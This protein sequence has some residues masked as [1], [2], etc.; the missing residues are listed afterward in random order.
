MPQR[1]SNIK[2]VNMDNSTTPTYNPDVKDTDQLSSPLND[3]DPVDDGT[4]TES[5]RNNS[6]QIKRTLVPIGV[7]LVLAGWLTMMI[8]PWI[9]LPC[10]IIG[11]ILSAIGVRIPAGPRRNFAITSIVAASVL[12]IVY[13]LFI[14][15]LY[16]I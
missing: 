7:I 1:V 4:Q 6:L 10:A 3:I 12:V 9:S 14:S 15:I 16:V 2:I 13:A 8:S 11:L 5:P